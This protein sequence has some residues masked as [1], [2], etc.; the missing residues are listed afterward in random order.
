MTCALNC[1]VAD[2]AV[3]TAVTT[4]I[5]S[6]LAPSF[7][8]HAVASSSFSFEIATRAPRLSPVATAESVFPQAP[9]CFPTAVAVFSPFSSAVTT[10]APRLPVSVRRL[11]FFPLC[12]G[13]N[14]WY[15]ALG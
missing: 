14:Q 8:L 13:R 10:R 9:S 7:S 2:P 6:L 11:C 4:E 3:S 12:R 5:V 1:I 15:A